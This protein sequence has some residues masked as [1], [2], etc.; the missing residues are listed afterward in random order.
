[1]KQVKVSDVGELFAQR[2]GVEIATICQKTPVKMKVASPYLNRVEKLSTVGMLIGA[3][4]E[5]SINKRLE[6]AGLTADFQADK[7][8]N[9]L[10]TVEGT[11]GKILRNKEGELLLNYTVNDRVTAQVSYLLDGKSVDAITMK[12]IEPWLPIKKESSKQAE[13]GL[14]EVEQVKVRTVK[15]KNIVCLNMRGDTIVLVE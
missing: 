15:L 10:T 3:S 11:S 4:Y 9:H 7:R 8:A 2:Q 1:M 12:Q 5:N 6:A 13:A 14:D